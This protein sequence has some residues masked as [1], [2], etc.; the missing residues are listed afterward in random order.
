MSKILVTGATGFI[1]GF[2]VSELLSQGHK[3][4]AS[5]INEEKARRASWYPAVK[6]IPFQLAEFDP[7]DDLYQFFDQPDSLVHLAWEGLPNYNSLFHLDVN[8]PRH[9]LFL[10]NMVRF[11]L[12]DMTVAGTCLEYG[13]QQGCLDENMPSAPGNPYAKAKD[14]LRE[15]LSQLQQA[16]PFHLKWARL[17][18]MYGQGQNPNSLFSQLD[19]ALKRGDKIF[20]MSG[21]EQVRDFLPVE[22]VA[23]YVAKIAVQNRIEGIINCCS[24]KP[25]TVKQLVLDYLKEKEKDIKLNFGYYPYPDYEPMSFWGDN[26]LIRT[27]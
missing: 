4:I 22:K 17:F 19:A 27:L 13:M 25:V 14:L 21:G 5:S 3:V 2:V 6:Y 9:A 7:S 26:S 23:E 11:G 20:N 12:R 24:G 10:E 16:I 1:G 18:Y 8:Y 15:R